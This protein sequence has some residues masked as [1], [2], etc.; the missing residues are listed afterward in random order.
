[1]SENANRFSE[2]GAGAGGHEAEGQAGSAIDFVVPSKKGTAPAN[3]PVSP[4][5]IRPASASP[6]IALPVRYGF[7]L[8][9]TV[10]SSFK[11]ERQSVPEL[12]PDHRALSK[13]FQFLE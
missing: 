9:T 10:G 1:M 11:Q 8:E 12:K 4:S 13:A 6:S 2:G 3:L 5:G 7:W